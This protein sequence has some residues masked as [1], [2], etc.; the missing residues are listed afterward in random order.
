MDSASAHTSRNEDTD[1]R[2]KVAFT[3][4]S[5]KVPPGFFPLPSS[6]RFGFG[7]T[8]LRHAGAPLIVFSSHSPGTCRHGLIIQAD[9]RD[10]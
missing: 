5:L 10:L 8:R 7:S 6:S 1:T 4:C 9:P 2:E 3:F